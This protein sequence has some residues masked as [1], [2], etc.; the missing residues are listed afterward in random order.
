MESGGTIVDMVK[1]TLIE[2]SEVLCYGLAI[3]G[4]VFTLF[5][6]VVFS[7]MLTCVLII[8]LVCDVIFFVITVIDMLSGRKYARRLNRIFRSSDDKLSKLARSISAKLNGNLLD[9]VSKRAMLIV[10]ESLEKS[11]KE[12]IIQL[13][14]C[15][16]K[17]QEFSTSSHFHDAYAADDPILTTT[18][19][20]AIQKA[21]LRSSASGSKVM[22]SYNPAYLPLISDKSDISLLEVS[23]EHQT[24]HTPKQVEGEQNEDGGSVSESEKGLSQPVSTTEFK[25]SS[26]R[27]P[28]ISCDLMNTERPH[29]SHKS[30][31]RFK[32]TKQNFK[33]LS[34]GQ[35]W[36]VPFPW[37]LKKKREKNRNLKGGH[38]LSQCDY[39]IPV[40]AEE[41][42][43]K[44]TITTTTSDQKL[45]PIHLDGDISNIVRGD[46]LQHTHRVFG[47]DSTETSSPSSSL[48]SSD[49]E[50]DNYVKSKPQDVPS[51]SDH[52]TSMPSSQSIFELPCSPNS[53]NSSKSR[54]GKAHRHLEFPLT[55][56]VL[57][58]EESCSS[59]QLELT[60][61]D[62]DSSLLPPLSYV[63]MHSTFPQSWPYSQQSPSSEIHGLFTFN[64]LTEDNY[65]M[66]YLNCI[67]S[68]EDA[69]KSLS[70][71]PV[72]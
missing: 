5:N 71:E 51:P 25:H 45:S 8:I 59:S 44:Q 61:K 21:P 14:T 70:Q 28:K 29:Y 23:E 48:S 46:N 57:P 20:Q 3:V 58:T 50:S 49:E 6:S 43:D 37:R 35:D 65:A 31:R 15:L 40:A 10:I 47:V 67:E 16:Q 72:C 17:D 60:Y 30:T 27:E 33:V 68:S 9:P 24:T 4:C 13:K 12:S 39:H 66:P 36:S 53:L 62:P 1:E 56:L 55:S 34:S 52:N 22:D 64:E 11:T 18:L 2:G 63:D 54:I 19:D 7:Y 69:D 42:I 38:I 32:P 26:L 41:N